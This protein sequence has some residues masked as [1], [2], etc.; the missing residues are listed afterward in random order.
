MIP[1]LSQTYN[2]D[3]RY[4]AGR[5]SIDNTVATGFLKGY[6]GALRAAKRPNQAGELSQEDRFVVNGPGDG[7]YS[8]RNNFRAKQ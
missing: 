4:K 8:F 1:K 5:N 2:V 6:L 3:A 7:T